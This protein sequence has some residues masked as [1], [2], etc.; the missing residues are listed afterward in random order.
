MSKSTADLINAAATATGEVTS[1]NI[2]GLDTSG[3]SYEDTSYVNSDE[4]VVDGESLESETGYEE[5]AIPVKEDVALAV[6]ETVVIT[7]DKGKRKVEIDFNNREQLKKYVQMAHG[8]RK[9]QAERDQT[10]QQLSEA[11]K[12]FSDLKETWNTLEAA[13]KSEGIEG[14]IDLLQ[15]E[16]GSHQQWVQS[17]LERQQF[18]SKASPEQRR[19]LEQQERL[20]K[21]EKEESRRQQEY[22]TRIQRMEEHR[23]ATE[24]KE[25]ESR[26]HPTFDKYRF[27]DKFGDAQTEAMFDEMLWNSALK[28]LEPY[29]EQGMKI[30]PELVDRQFR[31]VATALRKRITAQADKKAAKAVEQRKREATENVQAVTKAG[32]VKGGVSKEAADLINKGDLAGV[33]KQWSKFRGSF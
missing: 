9:W 5:E 15:G 28:R 25:L 7:D 4:S 1:D 13:F 27:A 26:I 16:K 21:M 10:R 33:F 8:A 12:E 18:L 32:Y 24:I 11:Q 29:E 2:E 17:K 3:V 31:E 19:L 30:T 6:K 23:E 14:V 20:D 22:E